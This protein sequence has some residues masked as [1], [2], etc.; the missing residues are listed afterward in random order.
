MHEQDVLHF[1]AQYGHVQVYA[2]L[3]LVYILHVVSRYLDIYI[4]IIKFSLDLRQILA[5]HA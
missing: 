5:A 3:C 4:D 2:L 1:F